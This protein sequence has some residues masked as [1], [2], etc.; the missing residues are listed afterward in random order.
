MGVYERDKGTREKGGEWRSRILQ[1]LQD[2]KRETK[3]GGNTVQTWYK[4]GVGWKEKI[5]TDRAKNGEG[6][7]GLLPSEGDSVKIKISIGAVAGA[8]TVY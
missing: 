5:E 7:G 6:K 8:I 3:G 4:K 2:G 1:R